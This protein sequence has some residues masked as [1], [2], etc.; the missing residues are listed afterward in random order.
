MSLSLKNK[1]FIAA[2]LSLAGLL[3]Y[4]LPFIVFNE[5]QIL[6][7]LNQLSAQGKLAFLLM[8]ALAS[9]ASVPRQVIAIAAG[10]A[11]GFLNGLLI[12]SL[13][14]M[15]GNAAQFLTSRCFLRP[16]LQRKIHKAIEQLDELA[17]LGQ[18]RIIL[19]LRLLPAGHSGMINLAAGA[20][21][22]RFMPFLSASY[23]GQFPQNCIFVMLGS[24]FRVDPLLRFSLSGVLLA[25]SLT[26]GLCLY[27]RYKKLPVFG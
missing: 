17:N 18:F 1:F 10:I 20:G 12:C 21:L 4:A 3:L 25:I 5:E 8:A 22:W 13:A 16:Y 15:L 11:F 7:W 26:F 6:D 14:I 2:L 27:Q 23:L 9:A 24:G 19:L